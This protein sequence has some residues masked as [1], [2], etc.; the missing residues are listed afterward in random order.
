M[1]DTSDLFD[2]TIDETV[3]YP[4]KFFEVEDADIENF[5]KIKVDRERAA[6][7]A[8]RKGGFGSKKAAAAPVQTEEEKA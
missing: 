5:R 2:P 8:A 6:A 3:E 1:G 4:E 7:A